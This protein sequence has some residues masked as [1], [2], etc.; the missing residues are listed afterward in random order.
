M[1]DND[2]RYYFS[3]C[4]ASST[5]SVQ[6]KGP[7][8]HSSLKNGRACSASLEINRLSTVKHPVSF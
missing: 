1:I 7:D 8:F 5:S 2:V 4:N 3:S 6:T